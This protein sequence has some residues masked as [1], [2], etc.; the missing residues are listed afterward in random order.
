MG[1]EPSEVL[2]HHWTTTEGVPAQHRLEAIEM[3]L[4]THLGLYQQEGNSEGAALYQP[5]VELVRR[6]K[7]LEDLQAVLLEPPCDDSL[8]R[9]PAPE[10]DTPGVALPGPGQNSPGR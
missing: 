5:L 4:A 8:Q 1:K 7:S 6:A 2:R 3:G 9:S 10:P